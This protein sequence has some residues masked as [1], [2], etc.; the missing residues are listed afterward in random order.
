MAVGKTNRLSKVAR[1]FNVGIHTIVEFLQKKGFDVELNPNTKVTGEMYDHIQNEYRTDLTVR[2]KSEALSKQKPQKETI[3]IEDL[4]KDLDTPSEK[5]KPKKEEVKVEKVEIP[6]KE[7]PKVLGKIDLDN[8]SKKK[9]E[10]SQASNEVSEPK[11]AEEKPVKEEKTVQPIE[12]KQ[13][14]EESQK[15]AAKNTIE[16]PKVVEKLT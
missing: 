1:E 14:P 8:L 12:E 10:E 13:I 3:S 9:N 11:K 7:A 2:K 5:E 15:P 6:K 16:E 4:R